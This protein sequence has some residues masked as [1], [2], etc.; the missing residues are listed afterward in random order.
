MKKLYMRKLGLLVLLMVGGSW[1]VLLADYASKSGEVG[2]FESTVVWSTQ[3]KFNGAPPVNGDVNQALII[4][5]G[6][7]ITRNGDFNPVTVTVKGEFI[8]NGNYTNNQ[9]DG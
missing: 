5:T 9:W 7:I 8:V 6:S 4:E 2:A 1:Q 3:G